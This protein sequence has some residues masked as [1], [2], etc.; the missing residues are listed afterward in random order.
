MK[1]PHSFLLSILV[2]AAVVMPVAA[3]AAAPKTKKEIVPIHT[4]I[5]AISDTSI[6]TSTNS[7]DP[8]LP[9]K[10]TTYAISTA[11][12]IELK[13]ERAT[14]KDLKVGMRVAVTVGHTPDAAAR[15]TASDPPHEPPKK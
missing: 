3:F 4:T 15:I 13:G 1:H 8:K 14:A 12:V 5:S 2:A 10:T 9:A 11:T 7:S 6:T